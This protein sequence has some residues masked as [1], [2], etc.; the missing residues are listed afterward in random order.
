MKQIYYD[1]SDRVTTHNKLTKIKD[2]DTSCNY[3]FE[4]K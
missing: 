2:K 1:W 4:K 3:F